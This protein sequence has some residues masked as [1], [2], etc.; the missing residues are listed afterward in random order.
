MTV[1][2]EG[3]TIPNAVVTVQL[4]AVFLFVTK[5]HVPAEQCSA[6]NCVDQQCSC[7]VH[8]PSY[9]AQHMTGALAFPNPKLHLFSSVRNCILLSPVNSFQTP[10]SKR[11][12]CASFRL[13]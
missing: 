5:S 12:P 3:E 11:V 10:G 4:L 7:L 6:K 1:A 8:L 9:F 13:E 2:G